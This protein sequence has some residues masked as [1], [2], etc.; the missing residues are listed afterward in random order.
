MKTIRILIFFLL[1][2][3]TC[4]ICCA[5]KC[6]KRKWNNSSWL[7]LRREISVAKVIIIISLSILNNESN[8]ISEWASEEDRKRVKFQND[9][10][11]I[12]HSFVNTLKV[13]FQ[14][15]YNKKKSRLS[16][17][18]KK[19]QQQWRRRRRRWW[20]KRSCNNNGN[21]RSLW[22]D[23]EKPFSVLFLYFV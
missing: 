11:Y 21:V 23:L 16:K 12:T 22:D 7:K 15:L 17:N 3:W 19:W 14:T 9:N 5:Y 10:I 20:W 18:M 13:T 8:F 1:S 4:S 6:A 2:Y